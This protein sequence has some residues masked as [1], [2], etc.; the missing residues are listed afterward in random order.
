MPELLYTFFWLFCG[1]WV[2]G[3]GAW[4]IHSKLKKHVE[5]GRISS[6]ERFQ[7]VRGW[8]LAIMVPSV[9]FCLLQITA[10]SDLTPDYMTWPSPQKWMALSVNVFCWGLL[11][12]WIWLRGG[13]EY[14]S[15][16]TTL[17]ASR[18]QTIVLSKY[19][20]RLLSLLIVASGLWALSQA[21]WNL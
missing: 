17:E 13:A 1:L 9:I 21:Q 19:S 8:F 14:L 6:A 3:L 5:S 4:Q 15:R 18:W 20:M 11:L 7:F 10:G 16:L 2:G 12:W